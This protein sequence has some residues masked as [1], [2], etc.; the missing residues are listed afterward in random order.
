[1]VRFLRLLV[2]GVAVGWV[3]GPTEVAWGQAAA[4]VVKTTRPTVYEIRMTTTLVIPPKNDR[5]NQV[6]VYHALPSVR[7]W[8]PSDSVHGALKVGFLPK[9]AVEQPHSP[10][11]SRH[12]LWTV[13]GRQKP[14]AKLVFR[15]MLTVSSPDRTVNPDDVTT[16]WQDYSATSADKTAVVDAAVV[17]SVPQELSALAARFKSELPPAKAVQAMCK[18]IVDTF[19][20]DASVPYSSSDVANILKNRR[21]HCGHQAT[22]LTQ[23]TAS[24]GIPLRTVWGMNLYALDGKTGGLQSVRADYTNIHTWAEAYFPGVGWVELEPRHGANAFTLPSRLIQN[25]RWFQNYSVW[26]KEGD[27]DRQPAWI[28][29]EGGFNSDF[30]VS[31]IIS[32]NKKP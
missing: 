19:V 2:I 29:R 9:S 15:S 21:G 3:G 5:V 7:P 8:S 25:N 23:L 11:G 1:M 24:A 20:Y 4:Q 31:H 13:D 12:L 27:R 14:G 22:L 16:R 30:G 18:W 6:R 10:T 28:P 17:R 32:F 26:L